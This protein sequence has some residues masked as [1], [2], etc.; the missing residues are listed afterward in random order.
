MGSIPPAESIEYDQR[1]IVAVIA[2]AQA[3]GLLDYNGNP[4]ALPSN[5]DLSQLLKAIYGIGHAGAS[6]SHTMFNT[7]H[8]TTSTR[9]SMVGNSGNSF[10]VT[11]WSGLTFTK[12][13]A[14]S[15]LALWFSG[16]SFTPASPGVGAA[17]CTITVG[18]TTIPLIATNNV[19]TDARGHTNTVQ[20]LTG[21]TAGAK[22]ISLVFRRLDGNAW[23][24]IF[25]PV[26]SDVSWLP[27]A[28]FG[29]IL[30]AEYEP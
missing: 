24:T 18:P 13:S 4:C 27:A 26:T 10:T 12:L 19:T 23:N 16:A 22:S 1:E 17:D 11:A 30:I 29:S 20:K 8:F 14:S 6:S 9:V 7:T 15:N 2:Y 25:C 3:Q 5:A 21:L 28:T